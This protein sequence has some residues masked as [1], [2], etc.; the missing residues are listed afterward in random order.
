MKRAR[1]T[2][3][4][5]PAS[6]YKK[7]S[8]KAPLVMYKTPKD[9]IRLYKRHSDYFA[10]PVNGVTGAYGALVFTLASVPGSAEFTTLYDQY[11]INAVSVCFYPKQTAV[12]SLITTDNIRAN[13]RIATAIDY[14]DDTVP[15]TMDVLRE[16]ESCE[17]DVIVNK[18]ERYIPKPLFLNNSGQNVNGWV[19]TA[20]PSTRFYGLKYGIEPTQ[21]VGAS[22]TYNV[23][24]VY[25]LAF[26]NT[27]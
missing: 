7:T 2:T 8:K 21:A 17:V 24:V 27:K 25:Y 15:L 26:K 11:K 16:Y 4:T 14:N 1:V 19:S 6:K 20:N 12:T 18:H 5:T 22:F 23:E 3:A 9:P 13:A 10:L